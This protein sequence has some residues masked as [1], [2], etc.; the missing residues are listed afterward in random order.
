MN[1]HFVFNCLNSVNR[2]ILLNQP[3]VASQYLT[4]FARLIRLVLENSRSEM[5]SLEKELETLGL[6]IEKEALRFAD[7]FTYSIE[8]DERTEANCID[9]PPM[10]IQPYV[11]NAIWHGLLHKK[12]TD[13]RLD[14]AVR[15]LGK[16]LQVE[17]TD[18]GV[19][20]FVANLLKSKSA[21]EHKSFGMRMTAERL[22]LLSKLYN[23]DIH[24]R[25]EDLVQPDGTAAGTRV[26]LTVPV[27]E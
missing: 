15:L 13:G 1:P 8:L 3:L 20:R 18:N 9:I 17:I 24:A 4:K 16:D 14:I 26:V 10:L 27:L 5:I 19:G 6:Y 7:R 12:G 22:Q 25:I 2:F 21:S 11:E 23:R